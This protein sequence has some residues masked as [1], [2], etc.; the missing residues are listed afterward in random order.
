MTRD[1][2]A[3]TT[4][5]SFCANLAVG[6]VHAALGL[7][8]HSWWFVTLG[9]YYI[10]LSV[11][12]FAVLQIKR[13]SDGDT[14]TEQFARRFTG[15]M[16]VLLAVCFAGTVIL[17]AV[18]DRGVKHHEIVMITIAL[19]TFTKATLAIVHLVQ[20]RRYPSPAFKTL[21]SISFADALVSVVSLQRSMLVTFEGMSAQEVQLFN[22]L[23]GSGV[24]V[25]VL[26]LGINLIG[27]RKITMAKSRIAKTGEKIAEGVVDGYKKIEQGVVDGYKKIEQGVVKGYTKLEDKFVD[28]YLTR[29]GE[30]VEE[31]K[32]RLKKQNEEQ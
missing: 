3:K 25:V 9:A 4:T 22:I 6:V 26:L 24:C 8:T 18:T 10:L 21:R 32:A 30:T 28:Q 2:L 17:A 15:V 29:D 13:R 20:A 16:L 23:T 19:Y 12:R 11:M 5:A 7:S 14:A 1:R 31:A 27:G